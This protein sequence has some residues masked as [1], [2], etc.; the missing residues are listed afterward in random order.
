MVNNKREQEAAAQAVTP[1]QSKKQKVEEK[2]VERRK[3]Q[4]STKAVSY[5]QASDDEAEEAPATGETT[6]KKAAASKPQAK[7]LAVG[8]SLPD[9]L[10][11]EDFEGEKHDL[12]SLF[13][14]KPGVIF[15]YPKA[16]T[17]GCTKQ[18]CGFRDNYEAF[19]AAGFSVFGMSAD[20]PAAQKKWKEKNT[21]PY[22]LISD[23]SSVSLFIYNGFSLELRLKL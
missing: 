15:F 12:K 7:L 23:R 9:N 13:A 3:S 6:T 1:E 5:N 21:F 4:R 2:S 22:S 11:V 10:E 20:T 14:E 8:D 16:N 19:E 17:P 18:A